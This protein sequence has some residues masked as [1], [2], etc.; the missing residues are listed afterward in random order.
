MTTTKSY[1]LETYEHSNGSLHEDLILLSLDGTSGKLTAEYADKEYDGHRRSGKQ[2]DVTLTG[3]AGAAFRVN[4][5]GLPCFDWETR[6]EI[7][8]M[9]AQASSISGNTFAWKD[10]IRDMGFR[11]EPSV[12][13]WVKK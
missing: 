4:S 12:K 6:A 9:I 5:K 7:E 1:K 10:M 13:A 11:W 8:A 2:N 3:D